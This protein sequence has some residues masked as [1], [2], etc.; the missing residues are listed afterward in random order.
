MTF[1][2]SA[3]NLGKKDQILQRFFEI[4]PGAASWTILVGLFWLSISKPVTASVLVIAF[5]LFWIFRLSYMTIFLLISYFRLAAEKNTDWMLRVKSLSGTRNV[6]ADLLAREGSK[7]FKDIISSWIYES[8]LKQYFNRGALTPSFESL[9]HLVVIPIA[10]EIYEIIEP[11]IQSLIQNTFPTDQMI[12]V[13]A[14]EERATDEVKRSAKVVQD[15]FSKFFKDF[16]VVIHPHEISGEAMVKGANATYAARKMTNYFKDCH[17]ELER[18]V[19][20]CFDADTVV[21]PNYFA[22][23]TYHYLISENREQASFQPIPVYNNNIW[24]AH[25]FARVLEMGSSFFQLIEATN[26]EKLVTFS[27]HSMSFKTL[28]QVGYWSVEMISDDSSIFWKAFIH[29]DGN[30]RVIPLPVTLSMD[31]VDAGSWW[32][33]ACNVYKQKRRW[34]WGVE[35]FPILMRAF[36]KSSQISLWDKMKHGIKMFESHVSWATWAIILAVIGWLPALYAGREFSETVLYYSA[37]RIAGIIFRLSTV[38]LVTTI[39][40][41][42]YMLPKTKVRFP[43]IRRCLLAA[44]WCLLPWIFIFLGALPALDAQTRLMFGAYMEFWV[45]D[46]NKRRSMKDESVAK[47][48]EGA[49]KFESGAGGN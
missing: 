17:I 8:E 11:G 13:L 33:T 16:L 27:S 5:L 36:L 25:G 35:N 3:R 22:C 46:K 41:S 28:V 23:L 4:L 34:A 29:F 43:F 37:P 7:K 10:K 32:K 18:V 14:V 39:V 42:L 47:L 12:V 44:Q 45:T 49:G 20:S 24:E 9:I 48:E 15:A 38:V 19:V 21:H 40:L 1:M 26:P 6:F 2:Y 31:V 30:Y